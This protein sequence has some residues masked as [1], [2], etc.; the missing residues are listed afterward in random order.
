MEILSFIVGPI[1]ENCYVIADGGDAIVVDP[2]EAAPELLTALDDYNVTTILLTHSHMDH[3]GGAAGVKEKTGA[4]LVCHR[5]AAPM[6]K[7]AADDGARM[8]MDIPP[9]PAPDEFLDEGDTVTVG[10]ITLRVVYVPG[11]APGHLAFIGDGFVAVGDV[12]FAGSVGRSDLPGG[13]HEVLL[14][15]IRTKLLPLDDDTV[16]LSG[17]GPA[18]TI[19]REHAMNPFLQ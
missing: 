14:D 18:T 19:G 17:H 7:A 3:V 5:D 4:K 13:S 15:S 11:H 1:Q 12:L 6:L 16:V 10:E 8:G 9:L 2:G